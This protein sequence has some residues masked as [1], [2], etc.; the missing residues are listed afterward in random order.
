MTNPRN[1][2]TYRPSFQELPAKPSNHRPFESR[3][4]TQFQRPPAV[5]DNPSWEDTVDKY[6]TLDIQVTVKKGG[7]H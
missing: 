2:K 5:Y 7:K 3:N 4:P 1:Y 6:A